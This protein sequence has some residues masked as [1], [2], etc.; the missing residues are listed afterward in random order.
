MLKRILLWVGVVGLL[1]AAAGSFA[2]TARIE[3]AEVTRLEI[4]AEAP[5]FKL[6]GVDYRYHSLSMYEDKKAIVVGFHC[7]H[8]P[9]SRMNRKAWV[10]LA[11]TYHDKGV[12]VLAI[13]PNPADKVAAD[14]FVQMAQVAKEN[15]YS[16]PY[17][18]DETQKT[19]A[20]YGARRTDD[21]FVLGPADEEGVRRVKYIGPLN[22]NNAAPHHVA[23]AL[24]AIL[25]GREVENKEVPE[26]G[27]TIKYRNEQERKAR[28][29]R[30]S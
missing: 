18:Y 10:D 1:V 30:L 5:E 27:C 19:A 12:Q 9:I 29:V 3:G 22:N 25:E 28:G 15:N 16:F 17:L 7:N 4:G 14:G 21:V 23:N 8:C 2:R 11:N 6:F 24:D 13:N 26:F 20:A